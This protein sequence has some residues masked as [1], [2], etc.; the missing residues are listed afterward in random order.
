MKQITALLL[1]AGQRGAEVYARYA[2]RFPNELKITGVAEPRK[3]RRE[4]FCRLHGIA[5]DYAFAS[6]QEALSQQKFAD[7][8][9]VCTQDREHFK[10]TV[11][12]LQMGYNVLC[13]KPMSNN[14][15]ELLAMGDAA[16]RTGRVLSICHV[17]RYAPFFIKLKE[18]LNAGMVGQMAAIQHIEEVGYW[19]M[20][21]SFVRGNWANS[22]ESSPMILQKCSHDLDILGWL[23]G[24][25]C[26]YV[27]SYGNLMHFRPEN[28]P[29]G[30]T[31]FCMDGCLYRD[32]CSYYA[33]R[34]YLEHPK[35]WSDGFV[36]VVSA[37]PS[38]ESVLAALAHGPY[39]RCVYACGNNVV[40][41]Q[42]VNLQYANGVT[43]NLTMS[44]FTEKCDRIINVMGSRG[45]ING[46][47]GEGTLT[48]MDFVRGHTTVVNV[49]ASHT[50]HGGGDECLMK[51]FLSVVRGERFASRSDADASVESH[52]AALAAEESRLNG[53][54]SVNLDE[55]M[56][57]QPE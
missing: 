25:S 23:V 12:A 57:E 8:V 7:C 15:Q 35:A 38:P 54:I 3:D 33:P 37:D 36:S 43:A 26:R 4:A 53:G 51:D 40:D 1:G 14:R 28:R 6:W 48:C 49:N 10:P 5:P 46:S 16:R 32:D 55:W 47:M 20:A 41:H 27:S 56:K 22:D 2:L 39:G 44:A 50:G 34:F 42:T 45:Q 24:S 19:H 17:L 52:L 11:Q 30:A 13:E 18:L 31:D 9:F 21:H 29:A